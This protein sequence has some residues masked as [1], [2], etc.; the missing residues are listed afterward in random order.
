VLE[1][2]SDVIPLEVVV[3]GGPDLVIIVL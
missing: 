1:L 3:S 2:P